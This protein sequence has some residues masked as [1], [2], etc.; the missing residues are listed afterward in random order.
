M[1][2]IPP[3]IQPFVDLFQKNTTTQANYQYLGTIQHIQDALPEGATP[4][5]LRCA[6]QG[7]GVLSSYS[8]NNENNYLCSVNAQT[9]VVATLYNKNNQ[10][11]AVIHFDHNI[12]S[13]IDQAVTATLS[14]IAPQNNSDVVSTLTGGIWLMGGDNISEPVKKV[15]NNHGVNSS[16]EQ[17][18]I[19]SCI[20]HNYGVV[21]NLQDGSINAF[22]Q[23]I[24]SVMQFINPLLA[25]AEHANNFNSYLR[26]EVRRAK[27]FMERFRLP[28]ISERESG[29]TFTEGTRSSKVTVDD[30]NKYHFNIHNI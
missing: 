10:T 30:V 14:Q 19:S 17:W 16:W 5:H 20:P 2:T 6:L 4:S 27:D 7:E 9:C 24:H 26:P 21:L 25:E 8:T 28:A 15:L 13:L 3:L 11:G 23:P 22:E 1:L 29:L 12:I 18:A